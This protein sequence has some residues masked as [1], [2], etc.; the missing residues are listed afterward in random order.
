MSTAAQ[1][2]KIQ[3]LI[4][5]MCVVAKTLHSEIRSYGSTVKVKNHQDDRKAT[6]R[7]FV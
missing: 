2:S 7:A 4:Y 5:S 3:T 1:L 6:G